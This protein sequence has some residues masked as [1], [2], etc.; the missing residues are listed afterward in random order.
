[1]FCVSA[2]QS[3]RCLDWRIRRLIVLAL[4]LKS[5]ML[6]AVLKHCFCFRWHTDWLFP[7]LSL[8]LLGTRRKTTTRWTI[9]LRVPSSVTSVEPSTQWT[10]PNS[11]VN[12][13]WGGC[14]FRDGET[15]SHL[16]HRLLFCLFICF[17]LVLFHLCL[18]SKCNMINYWLML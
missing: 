5:W 13:G 1:M 17:H 14:A 9:P 18:L 8:L 2:E 10:G 6:M 15:S 3:V 4:G 12:A 7:S 16:S 11:A